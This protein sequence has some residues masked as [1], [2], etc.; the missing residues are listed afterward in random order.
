MMVEATK[1]TAAS[2]GH[3]E[4]YATVAVPDSGRTHWSRP[5]FAL[6]GFATALF[7]MQVGSII[8][9]QF[10]VRVAL[11]AIAYGAILGA[12][13]GGVIARQAI[14]TGCGTNLL[15]RCLLGARG[16]ALF[17]VMMGLTTLT[18]FV[19]EASIMGAALHSAV[20]AI[21][22]VVFLG[23]IGIVMVPMLWFGMRLLA[24]IQAGTLI[25]YVVLVAAAIAI[26]AGGARGGSAPLPPLVEPRFGPAVVA[27]LGIMNG[28]VFVTALIVADFA[29][30]V[31][32]A[33]ERAGVL[34]LGVAFPLL[35]F[36]AAGI[37]GMVFSLHLGEAN[38]GIYFV[39]I[40]G[41]WGTLFAVATQLRINLSNM[42]LGSLAFAN[43]ALQTVMVAIPQRL[44]VCLFALAAT[45][46]LL[47]DLTPYLTEA[48]T[49]IGLFMTSF[50]V[51]LVT[52]FAL[53][54]TSGAGSSVDESTLEWCRLE[55]ACLIGSTLVGALLLAG[56]AGLSLQSVAVLVAAILTA[57]S[58][59]LFAGKQRA[60]R[61][62]TG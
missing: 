41:I 34:A 44:V 1:Q 29:R 62:V 43:A 21:S 23:S 42:Y 30:F 22:T 36:A 14:R 13:F 16:S 18:Y 52:R 58:Y 2:P 47:L 9:I 4:D 45:L 19:A 46:I 7:Y 31:D 50:T 40:L 28:I 37:L 11:V 26:V 24:R 27:A 8:T 20:P 55:L 6:S 17:S 53:D 35:C 60:A 51:L 12:L 59:A 32:R 33:Q 57:L 5:M 49:W 3:D 39:R 15:A 54:R 10:G 61:V 56:L 25:V 38:P 48:L